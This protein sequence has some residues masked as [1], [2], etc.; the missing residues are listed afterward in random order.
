MAKSVIANGT[1]ANDGTG[2]TL[3]SAATKINSN[4][5]EIYTMLGGDSTALTS[6]ISL[7]DGNVTFEGATA[8]SHETTLIFTD[9][10]VDRQIVFPN[11]SGNILLDSSTNTLTNKTLTSPVLTTPQ[12]NDTSANHQYVVAVSELAA[13]RTVTLP[14][15][16]GADEFT[17]NAHAQTLTNKTLTTPT[18]NAPTITGL[19][20]GGILKDSAGN[21]VLELTKTASA[22]NHV[23]ITNNATNSNPKISA[24]GTDT[25]VDIEIE[26][27]GT[28]GILLNSPEILKQ[29]TVSGNGALSVVL[30]YSEITKGTAGAYSLA[31]GVVGQVK[32]IS[33]SGAGTATITP[34]NFGA[35]TTLALQQNETGT[36]VFDG[37]NWQVLATYGGAVA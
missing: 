6:K 32:Y 11:A 8:D 28:G 26:G 23:N 19:S 25:N 12:I 29:E 17:F 30:P 33:V 31:D 16:T 36:L 14:L 22:V 13:D 9:P 35:G 21:E 2:D 34:A 5:S 10:T 4:F 15:L 27:Q 18:I 24:K 37:T 3:R 1:T 7:G 20:G